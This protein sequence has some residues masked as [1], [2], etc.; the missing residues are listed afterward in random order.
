MWKRMRKKMCVATHPYF[1][2]LS[3]PSRTELDYDYNNNR[4]LH[5]FFP[6][7][8]NCDMVKAV[9]H[10]CRLLLQDCPSVHC[11][12]GLSSIYM[13]IPEHRDTSRRAYISIYAGGDRNGDGGTGGRACLCCAGGLSHTDNESG[14]GSRIRSCARPQAGRRGRALE[15]ITIRA[16]RTRGSSILS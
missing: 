5:P 2:P 13:H 3:L 4:S 12:T 14:V 11:K 16:C 9:P 8:V 1:F 7:I 6:P 15:R 10:V